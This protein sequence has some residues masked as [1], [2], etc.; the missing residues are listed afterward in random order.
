MYV[1]QS[2]LNSILQQ[3]KGRNLIY[4]CSDKFTDERI[5]AYTFCNTKYTALFV[6]QT[7][8]DSMEIGKEQAPTG[9]P[10]FWCRN[11]KLSVT[12]LHHQIRNHPSRIRNVA[13]T[14]PEVSNR[15]IWQHD[16]LSC[17]GFFAVK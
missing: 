10:H 1:I 17:S 7:S 12:E 16:Q 5:M 13:Q 6:Y 8:L 3:F 9:F 2:Q 14:I 4:T 15:R 11:S